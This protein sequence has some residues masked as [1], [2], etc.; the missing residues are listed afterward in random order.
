MEVIKCLKCNS[1]LKVILNGLGFK[2]GEKVCD[3]KDC[4]FYGV[5]RIVEISE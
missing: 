2:T 5:I 3:N 4:M 1:E